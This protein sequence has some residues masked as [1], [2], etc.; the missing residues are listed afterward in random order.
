MDAKHYADQ[1]AV[2]AVTGNK[3]ELVK[4]AAEYTKSA[5]FDMS[6]LGSQISGGLQNAWN[7]PALRNAMIGVGAG[8]L[9]GMLQPKRKFRNA[10]QYGLLGGLGGLGYSAISGDLGKLMDSKKDATP[11]AAPAA[12][13]AA[14]SLPPV[15]PAADPTK[16]VAAA[17]GSPEEARDVALAN[18][19]SPN[20]R[21]AARGVGGT[22]GYALGQTAVRGT[23][24]AADAA[25]RYAQQRTGRGLDQ[26]AQAKT[27]VGRAVAK[28]QRYN[29]NVGPGNQRHVAEFVANSQAAPVG[30]MPQNAYSDAGLTSLP[31][32]QQAID[33]ASRAVSRG[34]LSWN[35]FTASKE[36]AAIA[37][38][39]N[40]HNPELNLTASK[41]HSAAKAQ[42]TGTPR[43]NQAMHGATG[44]ALSLLPAALGAYFGPDVNR[45]RALAAQRAG[46]QR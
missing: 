31:K 38:V 3:T 21:L 20:A 5:A 19:D 8:G 12:A 14:G 42:T 45:A 32:T 34:H 27:D 46:V 28:L 11:P 40:T 1:L 18:A 13:P 17:P 9:V 2:C 15:A 10:L 33:L 41:L 36:R 35:P 37:Q 39:A 44:V 22:F 24:A 4:V 26:L 43:F 23:A 6:Q 25:A 30:P 29:T 7:T 16:P